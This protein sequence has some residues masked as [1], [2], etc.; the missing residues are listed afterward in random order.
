MDEESWLEILE[1]YI[2]MIEKQDEIISRMSRIIERQVRDL[3][4]I[5]N[6]REFSDLKLEQEI[7]VME[8]M[9]SDY[10]EQKKL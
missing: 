8:E 9:K 3:S 1:L 7:A 5:K 10:E 2:E 4:L 6:D